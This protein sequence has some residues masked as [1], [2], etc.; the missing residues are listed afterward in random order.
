MIPPTVRL[1]IVAAF[2]FALTSCGGGGSDASPGSLIISRPDGIFELPTTPNGEA[3]QL[4]APPEPSTFFLDPAI[5]PDAKRIAY[6]VQPPPVVV[7]GR[8]DAG[9]DLWIAD[10]D[11]G[12]QR[13]VLAHADPNQ[14]IRAP[15][16][17]DGQTLLA[18]VQEIELISG[19]TTVVYTLQRIDVE[20]AD[21]ERLLENVL[22][23][24]VSPDS[25]RVA[26]SRLDFRR[27]ETFDTVNLDGTEPL[28]LIDVT[29]ELAPFSYPRY[30]PDGKTIAFASADQSTAPTGRRL[31]AAPAFALESRFLDGLPQDIWTIGV[32]GEDESRRVADLKEDLP[33]L[34]WDGKGEHIFVLGV[35]GLYDVDIATGSVT[36]IGDGAF[37]G[38]IAWAP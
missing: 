10:R 31:V 13:L 2:A 37:H 12:N 11:G 1:L 15:Q 23:F 21:R 29:D 34:T 8:Y 20:T 22:A 18:I 25:R 7:D 32:D 9:S 6:V 33:A 4:I 19:V 17:L 36:R 27:G 3:T 35:A 30:A 5:S 38:Q 14:L 26:Y 28:T 16:W 24:D